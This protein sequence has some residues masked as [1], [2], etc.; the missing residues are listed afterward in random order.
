MVQPQIVTVGVKSQ[1]IERCWRVVSLFRTSGTSKHRRLVK[2][3]VIGI[4]CNFSR[5]PI[6]VGLGLLML[7]NNIPK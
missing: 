3:M 6:N 1:I 5:L 7:T 2:L 4:R